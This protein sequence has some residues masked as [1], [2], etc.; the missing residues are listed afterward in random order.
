MSNV[1]AIVN[2]R[3]RNV[4]CVDFVILAA[5]V[6]ECESNP[7]HN[8]G[9]CVDGISDYTCTCADGYSGLV[10][11]SGEFL[12]NNSFRYESKLPEIYNA[13]YKIK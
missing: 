13:I 10:C 7:C 2:Q 5:D 8:G 12:R 1:D 11:D 6:N 9:Q 3:I 4:M